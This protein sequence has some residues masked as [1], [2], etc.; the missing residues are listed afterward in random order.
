M[1]GRLVDTLSSIFSQSLCR[2]QTGIRNAAPC[3][4]ASLL[5]CLSAMPQTR[6]ILLHDRWPFFSCLCPPHPHSLPCSFFSLSFPPLTSP[7]FLQLRST[8]LSWGLHST[9]CHR[10]EGKQMPPLLMSSPQGPEALSFLAS[11][12]REGSCSRLAIKFSMESLT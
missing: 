5:L 2:G 9:D 1:P 3:E 4:G 7:A 11:T 8:P 10:G 6:V 12:G